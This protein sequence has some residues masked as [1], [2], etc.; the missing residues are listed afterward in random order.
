MDFSDLAKAAV[1][2]GPKKGAAEDVNPFKEA[3][4]E[5]YDAMK[6]DDF[7]GFASALESAVSIR[8][9]EPHEVEDSE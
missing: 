2:R 5:A 4:R 7:D 9:S 8:L 6:S 3:L 1:K